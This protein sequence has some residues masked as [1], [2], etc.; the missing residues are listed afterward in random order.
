MTP[1]K[2]P[3][4]NIWIDL[5]A[6][7]C[8]GEIVYDYTSWLCVFSIHCK[9]HND[10]IRIRCRFDENMEYTSEEDLSVQLVKKTNEQIYQPLLNEWLKLE[11]TND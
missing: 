3:E 7:T 6:I 11:N 4:V 9:F 5:E 1:Y 10:P 2:I 8:I